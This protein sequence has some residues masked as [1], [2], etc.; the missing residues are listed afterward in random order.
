MQDPKAAEAARLARRAAQLASRS[1]EIL[2]KVQEE[3]GESEKLVRAIK[4]VI[5][6]AQDGTVAPAQEDAVRPKS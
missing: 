1:Q 2:D 6:Q 3:M 4:E 5:V